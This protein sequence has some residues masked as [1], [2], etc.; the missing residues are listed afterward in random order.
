MSHNSN[1][2][3]KRVQLEAS[4][5]AYVQVL[6]SSNTR[7]YVRLNAV[8]GGIAVNIVVGPLE[9]PTDET[10]AYTLSTTSEVEL[11]DGPLGPIWARS[12][13]AASVL[14]VISN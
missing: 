14:Q 12:T 7:T 1:I 5:G 8:P 6:G 10:E 2:R 4:T 11:H 3:T 9:A 13:A